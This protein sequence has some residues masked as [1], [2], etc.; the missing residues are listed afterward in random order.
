MEGINGR[1][2]GIQRIG[3]KSRGLMDGISALEGEIRKRKPF[4]YCLDS[5]AVTAAISHG[6]LLPTP[7]LSGK[8]SVCIWI[9]LN[10]STIG[11]DNYGSILTNTTGASGLFFKK[12]TGNIFFDMYNGSDHLSTA[13][14]PIG[15][16]THYAGVNDGVNF[17]HYIN[18][19]LDS[20][21]SNVSSIS[22]N[23]MFTDTVNEIVKCYCCE[24]YAFSGVALSAAEVGLISRSIKIGKGM[25]LY[26]T[27]LQNGGFY[28]AFNDVLD[29]QTIENGVNYSPTLAPYTI[30]TDGT[31]RTANSSTSNYIKGK[32][33]GSLGKGF[34]WENKIVL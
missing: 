8:W 15:S 25:E 2:I 13:S 27:E 14:T 18:G 29:A 19:Q 4:S 34:P 9:N 31:A 22:V 33:I 16:W 7:T 32:T 6:L 20:T 26:P 11:A 23:N 17:R 5:T 24:L 1:P 3:G 28:F 30:S 12:V 10:S 21:F